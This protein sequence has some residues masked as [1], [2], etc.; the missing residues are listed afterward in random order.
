MAGVTTHGLKEHLM[1]IEWISGLIAIVVVGASV[2]FIAREIPMP[3]W[4]PA[5]VVSAVIAKLFG[6]KQPVDVMQLA[7]LIGPHL[8]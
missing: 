4:W 8:S 3:D 6:S 5:V 2:Y 1:S 7:R